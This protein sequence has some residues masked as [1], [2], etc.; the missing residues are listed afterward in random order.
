M[1]AVIKYL[2]LKGLTQN[3]IAPDMKEVLGI[4][5]LHSSQAAVY[6]WVAEFQCGSNRLKMSTVLD[7]FLRSV[8]TKTFN[9]SRI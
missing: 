2:H 1:D 9:V 7:A 4:M 8:P 6:R 3:E 5:P